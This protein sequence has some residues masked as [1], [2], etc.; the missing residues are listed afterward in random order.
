ML[1]FLILWRRDRSF[2]ALLLTPIGLTLA[3]AFARQ[4]PFSDRPILFLTPSFFTAIGASAGQIRE[5]LSRWSKSLS[6]IVPAL[7]T[8]SAVYPMAKTPPVYHLED[9]KPVLAYMQE[10][11]RPGDLVYVYY[12][13]APEVTFYAGAFGLG[14]NDYAVGGCNRGN[15]RRY[16]NELDRFR[17]RP[18]LWVL[19]TH[20]LA[21][22]RE[23]DDILRYLDTIGLRRESFVLKSRLP[24]RSGSAAEVFLYDLSDP[25]R[26]S[27][28]TSVSL[29]VT[30]PSSAN[31]RNDCGEGPQATV[32]SRGLAAQ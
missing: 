9:M 2:A 30:G 7:L 8:A 26:L 27:Q 6:V 4:Y 1:G 22:Y 17:G 10:R 18:R 13:A 16:F 32:P 20:A 5:W 23:R 21:L 28:A 24:G 12:G 19:M 25:V 11:R 3:A 14:E 31:A 29:P 15:T